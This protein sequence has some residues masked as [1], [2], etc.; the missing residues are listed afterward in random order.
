MKPCIPT[1]HIITDFIF[2]NFKRFE[3]II[4]KQLEETMAQRVSCDHMFKTAA[5][6]GY[7]R[8]DGKW[9]KQHKAVILCTDL[10]RAGR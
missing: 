8:E 7:R 3:A 1:G 10:V 4:T 2:A 5:N 6:I 9:V